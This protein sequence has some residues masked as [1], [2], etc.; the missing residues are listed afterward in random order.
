MREAIEN[1]PILGRLNL[2]RH[3]EDDMRASE[4]DHRMLSKRR[5]LSRSSETGTVHP[6][7]PAV[8]LLVSFAMFMAA[9]APL[10]FTAIFHKFFPTQ[11]QQ[12]PHQDAA[13]WANET[14]GVYYCADSI[15]FGETKGAYMKQVEALDRGYQPALRS[16]CTGPA[17]PLHG[18]FNKLTAPSP[19]STPNL[20]SAEPPNSAS[21]FENP[22]Y[23]PQGQSS[24]NSGGGS[25]QQFIPD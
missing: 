21:P 17:W 18:E 19:S 6:A 22:N 3:W 13:V 10:D 2:S 7:V 25:T 14:S 5:D 23:K 15:L 24:P 12:V 16:Y 20:Q 9:I 11:V 4:G 8:L 1:S